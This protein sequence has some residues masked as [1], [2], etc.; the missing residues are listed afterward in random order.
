MFTTTFVRSLLETRKSFFPQELVGVWRAI[1]RA[2]SWH[3]LEVLNG[4]LLLVQLASGVSVTGKIECHS[5]SKCSI[6]LDMVGQALR[7]EGSWCLWHGTLDFHILGEY[8][9]FMPQAPAVQVLQ[10]PQS[11]SL[12]S[13]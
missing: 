13:A 7:L 10:L 6:T 1:H 8:L 4:G 3:R 9:I 5:D 2:Q 11:Q 12:Q